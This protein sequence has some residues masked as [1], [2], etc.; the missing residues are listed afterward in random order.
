MQQKIKQFLDI[1]NQ[2]I[3]NSNYFNLFVFEKNN[4]F[5]TGFEIYPVGC[6]KE[7]KR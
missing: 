3:T 5:G 6:R 2:S 4:L 7:Q 1:V